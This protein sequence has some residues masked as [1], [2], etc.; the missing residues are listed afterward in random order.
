MKVIHSKIENLFEKLTSIAIKIFGSAIGFI[1]AL[2]MVLIYISSPKFYKQHFHG[3]ILDVIYCITFLGFFIIQKSFNRFSTALHLKMNELVAAHDK[4]SNRMVNIEQKTE[5][6]L[7]ELAKHYN[8]LAEI[9][10]TADDI[11]AAHSIETIIETVKE[12]KEEERKG[13]L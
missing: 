2:I 10:T 12:K 9:A 13:N 5:Q 4:A 8:D 7:N 3:I 6:E 1:I 11:H